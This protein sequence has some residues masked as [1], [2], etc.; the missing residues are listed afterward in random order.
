MDFADI[1]QQFEGKRGSEP[2]WL[3]DDE[4]TR[5]WLQLV[6][7]YRSECDAADRRRLLDDPANGEATS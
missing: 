2:G 1:S 7:Q 6:Q 4:L 5:Y 3:V